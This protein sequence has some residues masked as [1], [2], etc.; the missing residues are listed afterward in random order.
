[1]VLE[2]DGVS[3]EFSEEEQEDENVVKLLQD[4]DEIQLNDF[5][6]VKFPLKT[7]IIYYVGKVTEVINLH[8]YS[9]NFL[10]RKTPGYTFFYPVVE[11]ISTVDRQNVVLKL[12]VPT[13]AKTAR[14]SSLLSF[15]IDLSTYN[16]N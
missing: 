1:M 13:S 15:K 6:L 9:L 11:D 14:T 2:S 5:L 4:D 3:E 16:V 10:R 8:E 7:N 12:P